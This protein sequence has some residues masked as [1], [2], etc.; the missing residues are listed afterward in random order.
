M[1]RIRLLIL[2]A[3]LALAGC[4]TAPRADLPDAPLAAYRPAIALSGHLAIQYQKDGQAQSSSG[5]FEWA[6]A[7]QQVDVSLFSP[8]GQTVA[9]IHV[10]P[11]MASLTEAGGKVHSAPDLDTLTQQTLGWTLPVRGLRDWLQGYATAADGSRFAAAPRHNSVTTVDGWRL[12]YVSWHDG[13][14]V[15]RPRR[16]DCERDGGPDGA[17]LMLRI[18]LDEQVQP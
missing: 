12:R 18:S 16:I 1:H 4:A 17:P 9:V 15:A 13:A 6:Q 11:G 14:A 8:L 2:F 7:G 5:S 10:Q 3:C